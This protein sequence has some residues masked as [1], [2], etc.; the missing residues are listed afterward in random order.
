MARLA[1][2]V[3]GSPQF[4]LDGNP[5]DL[6]RRKA[7]ALLVYLAVTGERHRR[8]ALATLFWPDSDQARAYAYLR[9]TLWEI[10]R[11]LG[12]GWLLADRESA[13]VNPQADITLDLREFRALLAQV[14]PHVH[15]GDEGC[16]EC[17]E[18]L[19]AATRLYRG[20][21]LVGFGL[22][23]SPAFDEWQFFQAEEAR[24]A[25]MDGLVRLIHM[26][27]A[28]NQLEQAL[29]YARRWS[30]LDPINEAA[31]RELMQLYAWVGQ[32][33]A[34][35]RQYRECQQILKQELNIEPEVATTELFERIQSGEL[36]REQVMALSSEIF[37]WRRSF[38]VPETAD[39]A[40]ETLEAIDN[41]P[42]PATPFVGRQ[43]E[44]QEIATQLTDPGYRLITLLGPGGIGKTRLAIQ[45]ASNQRDHFKH[46]VCFV[47][48]AALRSG[49][50][51]LPSIMDALALP[52][53]SGEKKASE[54]LI[55]FLGPRQL[56]LVLDN[57]EHHISEAPLVSVILQQA[58]N[59]KIL[60]TSRMRLNLQGEW[61]TEILG[62]NF[63][64]PQDVE[65]YSGDNGFVDKYCAAEFFLHAAQ[66][67]RTDFTITHADYAAVARITQLVGGIPLGLE[68]AAS[69][70]N[71][72]A[73][74]EIAAEI[75]QSLDFLESS[76]QDVPE[77]Q[78]SM[79]AVFDHSWKLMSTREQ[80]IFP[81]LS[82][83]R[84]GF[85]REA[86]QKVIGVSLRDL[87]GLVNK[88]LIQRSL[89]GRFDFHPLL[90]QYATLILD[91]LDTGHEV[92]DAHCAYF[93]AA[94]HDLGESMIDRRQQQALSILDADIDNAW[95]A[96][97]WAVEHRQIERIDQALVGLASFLNRQ[98]RYGEGLNAMHA[99]ERALSNPQD[100]SE[101]R[102]YGHLLAWRAMFEM[103]L[104]NFEG[105]HPT[106]HRSWEQIDQAAA[107]GEETRLERAFLYSMKGYMAAENG[108]L[109]VSK[110]LIE[111]A[112]EIYKE[113]D[114]KYGVSETLFML[115]WLSAQQGNLEYLGQY[116]QRSLEIK[117]QIGD[118]YGMADELYHMGVQEAFHLGNLEAGKEFLWE[119]SDIFQDLGD[120]ISNARSLRIMDDV[121]ILD[122]WYEVA[123]VT[124]QKMMQQYKKLG[125]LAG[126]GS[127]Y[128]QLGEAYYHLGD[129]EDAEAQTR[130][131][132]AVLEGRVYPFEQS[133]ARWQLGMTLLALDQAE[134]A[135]KN[136]QI[137]IQSYTDYRRQ[138][139]V[140][141][142]YAGLAR[143]EYA[144]GDYDQAWEHTL[145]AVRLL[146]EFQHFFW[147][148]YALATMALLL[149]HRGYEI[150]A[151]EVYSL[152]KRYNFVANSKWFED[153][154]GQHIENIS[155][156][157]P[158]KKVEAARSRAQS[159][160]VWD[161]TKR[162][163]EEFDTTG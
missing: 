64:K 35:I 153:V 117:R 161:T 84:G 44:L 126:I 54:C 89:E 70:V 91:G 131:A 107:A 141:S 72:L 127:Q 125:D 28:I 2:S 137:C 97:D 13:G 11:T 129:Y 152:I 94:L 83:F 50:P 56:L 24:Q 10:N 88:S 120:P 52:V 143:A 86:A 73:P 15:P 79:R 146:L 142:A 123:L 154:Y 25:L 42:I 100:A 37:S 150:R 135:C 19:E 62:L 157:L 122:G 76:M 108:D 65:K 41:L 80:A 113:I 114:H 58:P 49:Q 158:A 92:H 149:A 159:M 27:V 104:G 6:P 132:L 160:E 57:F 7:T 82:V 9:N 17:A 162:L 103:R 48:L 105:S 21:F 22:P 5:I 156:G 109:E 151:V 55:D 144:L 101:Q 119:S 133:F 116:Q 140:G 45:A 12:E 8:D 87:M 136:F 18:I 36:Q 121:Y 111:Q 63:P 51:I 99:A 31:H 26:Q 106:F 14:T 69:W 163:L 77:R 38:D 124:R 147:M 47:S 81:K 155:K 85:S 90:W 74:D 98:R 71:I 32:R 68:L 20:D 30:N 148:F 78:R 40:P 46:G 130:E 115:G 75:E 34:A 66:R 138:D 61:V 95:A 128:T 102:V 93:A 118:H 3:L 53:G 29:E 16:Q 112:L 4:E 59:V 67:A 39:L 23:D 43:A 33:N 110:D 60:V 134:E 1:I 96:W 139:G 145:L